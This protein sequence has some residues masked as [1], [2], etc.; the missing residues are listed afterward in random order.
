M[1]SE[2]LNIRPA[3]RGDLSALI[4]IYAQDELGG[5]SD[6]V[7]HLALPSYERAFEVLQSSP[8][9]HLFVAELDREIVG[10][11]QL[12]VLTR[13]TGQGSRTLMVQSVQTKSKY[14]GQGIGSKMIEFA[15]EFAKS[16]DCK[17]VQLMSNSTRID[18]HRFYSRIGFQPAHTGFRMVLK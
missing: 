15:V 6:T 10:T 5:H 8:N 1:V 17:A 2:T 4:A 3:R 18:A 13:L 11:F 9:E 12:V 16:R 7:E 14:R